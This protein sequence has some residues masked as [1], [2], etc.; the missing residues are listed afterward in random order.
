MGMRLCIAVM[1]T[2]FLTMPAAAA[3]PKE[4]APEFKTVEAKHYTRAEGVELSPEF[5][6]YLYA[7]LRKELE[8]TKL[9]GQVVGEGEVVSDADALNSIVVEGTI[10]EYKKGSAVKE[11]LIGFTAG[12]RSLKVETKLARRSDGKQ[13]ASLNT[14]VKVSTRWKP[15]VM[16]RAAAKEIAKEVKKALKSGP[17]ATP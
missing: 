17:E 8:K 16:A 5:T 14:H 4:Q 11:H 12:W 15:D 10:T 2:A 1:A 7:E 13:L 6:D 9:F 3:S